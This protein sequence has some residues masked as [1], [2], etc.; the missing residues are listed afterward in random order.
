MKKYP[1]YVAFD[2]ILIAKISLIYY[3]YFQANK[4]KNK[5]FT[6]YFIRCL[7]SRIAMNGKPIIKETSELFDDRSSRSL[8]TDE[9]LSLALAF[10]ALETIARKNKLIRESSE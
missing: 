3:N 8:F 9:C 1:I 7:Y 6:F 5:S 10:D 2:I 4:I